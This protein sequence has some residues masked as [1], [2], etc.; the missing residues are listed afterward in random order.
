MCISSVIILSHIS[1]SHSKILDLNFVLTRLGARSSFIQLCTCVTS[2]LVC[3][4][5]C[6]NKISGS[7]YHLTEILTVR[8]EEFPVDVTF[9]FLLTR[10]ISVF[11]L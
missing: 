9:F 2:T 3:Y 11:V 7:F 8:D 10:A 6:D 1:S 5:V 4:F